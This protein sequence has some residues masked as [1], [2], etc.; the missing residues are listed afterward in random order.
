MTLGVGQKQALFATAFDA[1][2]NLIASAK[3]TFRSSDTMIAQVRKDGTVIGV[4]PGLAK[5]EARSQGKFAS[6]AVLIAGV[7]PGDPARARAVAASVLTLDP[8][9][10]SLFPGEIVRVTPRALREDGSPA[11]VGRVTWRSLNP[12]VARIDTGGVV[13]G[14]A[15]GKGT[16]E[17]SVGGRLVAR[18]PVEVS[19]PDFVLSRQSLMLGPEQVDSIRAVVPSQ[20]NRE[21]RGLLQWRSLDSSVASI[22]PTGVVRG[23]GAGKTEIVATGFSLERRATVSVHREPQA[24]VVSP[25]HSAGPILV[26]LRSTRQF[27]AVAEAEDS[28][29]IPEA[30]V[31]W[32]LADTA[33]ATFDRSS[34]VL[35]PK[36]IGKTT[37]T[38]RLADIKPAVWT[39]HIIPGEI[40]LHP[41]RVGLAAGQRTTVAAFIRD[42]QG[43][44]AGKAAAAR[45]SSDRPEVAL[46]RE[47][48]VIDALTPGHTVVT[49]TAPWGKSAKADVFVTGDLLL[50]S[51]RGGSFGI[52]QMRTTG[53]MAL[54]P[55]MGD[56]ATSFQAS[57]SPDRTRI[58]F[59]SNRGGN[60][61]IYVMDADG[62]NLRRLTTDPRNEGEPV[63]TP[64][65]S[66]IVYTSTRGTGTQIAV[67][68][69]DGSEVVLTATPGGNHSPAISP[70][71]ATI[72][73][74]SAR[75]GNQEIYAMGV[76]GRNQRRLTRSSVRESNPRFFPNGDLAYVTE[77]GKGSRVMRLRWGTNNT[78]SILQTEHPIPSLAVS[79]N[80]DRLAYV[81]GRITDAAKGRVEFSFFLQSTAPGN[82]PVAVPL[83]PG[84]QISTPSF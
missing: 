24:L 27:T 21:I 19:P 17:A 56:T 61:D 14:V 7:A 68:S 12:D 53:S 50:S 11:L 75:D 4:N 6:M 57:L 29:P 51:N 35:T 72:A 43:E 36:A 63:W 34:G 76:D 64:D 66:R 79:R 42:E 5:I 69:L 60:F 31:I 78:T 83:R 54:L 48:G 26:A 44:P 38:A 45:W 37:L 71:G 32:E 2:G 28:T 9:S 18:L 46:A 1:R 16:I 52:Y 23:K 82:H 67:M 22:S 80:G 10:V 73:F 77:R 41:D 25:Q 8:G 39:I 47:G 55:V 33:L 84:E 13:A 65:G 70:D 58:A 15:P 20:G 40:G 74:V 81:V 59:S 49:A 62:R 30:R 3:F